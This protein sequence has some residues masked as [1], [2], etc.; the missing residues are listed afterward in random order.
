MSY[1]VTHTSPDWDAIMSCWLLQ[2]HGG[3][4]SARVEFVNT[5]SPD[6]ET[7]AGAVA[8]VD[9]GRIYNPLHRRY[10]HHQDACADSATS[11]VAMDLDTPAWLT[12]LI[13]LVHHGDWGSP[14]EGAD[15][16]RLVGLHAAL[17]GAKARGLSD[18]ELLAYGYQL[19][20]DVAAHLKSQADARAMLDSVT[21]W[22]SADGLVW[23]IKDG[24]PQVTRAAGELGARLVV[25]AYATTDATP[26]RYG[27]G[28]WRCGGAEVTAPH[29]GRLVETA[30]DMSRDQEA[31]AMEAELARWFR[32]PVGFFAGWGTDKAPRHEAPAVNVADVA[33]LISDMWVRS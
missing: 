2:R 8:V 26:P 10:D 12:P 29:V 15:W 30:H 5:G 31:P 22:K 6:A 7:L 9:T 27:F 33:K 17:S 24:G 13:A 3:F 25:Y 28:C 21:V 4:E 23:A 1:I 16:L 19:L 11:R 20:D 18:A 14:G 32:H